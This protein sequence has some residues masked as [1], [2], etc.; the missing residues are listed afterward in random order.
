[1]LHK[2]KYFIILFAHIRKKDQVGG[3]KIK[4]VI[5]THIITF[6]QSDRR[7]KLSRAHDWIFYS[8]T[9][10]KE[11]ARA[12]IKSEVRKE[13]PETK[14]SDDALKKRMERAR[15]MFRIFNTIGKEK[16]GKIY[17][18]RFMSLPKF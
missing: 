8:Y 11:G 5:T 2:Q 14:F 9:Y 18:S 7:G 4:Y 16:I 13:I 15:K 12:L 6:A 10:G 1:M 3:V 17:P